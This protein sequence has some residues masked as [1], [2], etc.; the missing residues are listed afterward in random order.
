MERKLQQYRA[1]LPAQTHR[2]EATCE[3]VDCPHYLNGWK[4]AVGNDGAQAYYVRKDSGRDFTEM[5]EGDIVTFIFPPGQ[6][7]FRD[8][9]LPTGQPPIYLR[10]SRGQPRFV[11]KNGEEWVEDFGEHLDKVREA[12]GG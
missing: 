4:T 5:I 8:H 3:E 10:E 9:S 11:H 2:R 12:V 7:C 1:V 6:T